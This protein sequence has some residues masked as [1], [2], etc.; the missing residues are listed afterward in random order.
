MSEEKMTMNTEETEAKKAETIDADVKTNPDGTQTA[1]PHESF[2]QK[3]WNG[4]CAVGRG[5][6]K[7]APY[8]LAFGAGAAT[9]T[10]AAFF[11]GGKEDSNAIDTTYT[12]SNAVEQK[13]DG[14]TEA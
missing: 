13:D 12:E 8:V 5:I 9:A 11:L 4:V 3:V 10:G 14:S 2:G 1:V 6:K 7:A